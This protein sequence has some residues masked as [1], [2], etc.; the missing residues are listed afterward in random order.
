MLIIVEK[1]KK[2]SIFL[3]SIPYKLLGGKSQN[4]KNICAFGKFNDHYS[5]A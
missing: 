2:V 5:K 1:I 4:H 3:K